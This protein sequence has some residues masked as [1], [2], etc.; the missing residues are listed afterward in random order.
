MAKDYYD[1]L[2]VQKDASPEQIKK[3]YRELALK[4]HPDRNASKEAEA[5]FKEINEA[6]AVLGDAQKR[7][8]YDTYGPSGFGQRFSEEEIFRN[9]NFNDIFREMG[10]NFGFGGEMF[11]GMFGQG[12]VREDVGQSILYRMP[13][14]LEELAHGTV[15]EISVRHQKAC[16]RCSG[17]GAE[18]GSKVRKCPEC[19]GTGQVVTVRNTFLGSMQTITVCGRCGGRGKSYEKRCRECGGRGTTL[20]NEKINV[21]VPAGVFNGARLRLEGMGDYGQGGAGDL[22]VEIEELKHK[23]FTREGDNVM[24]DVKV[25]FYT[26]ILGGSITIPTLNGNRDVTL[27]AGAQ[28]GRRMVLKG[29]GIK[30]MRGPGSGDEIVTIH[31]DLPHSMSPE[32]RSLIERF[33]QLRDGKTV[34][35]KHFGLF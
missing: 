3:A 28:Q 20:Q 5:K 13:L 21:T 7:Q 2:G 10:A 8:Q 31:I 24:A 12:A 33:R 11:G 32:E 18:P 9:F 14:T 25:P 6:Y 35:S 27:E 15:K 26:A 23:I 16:Q 29:D 22:Y 1:T 19:N 17:N 30:R 34:D 4:Y